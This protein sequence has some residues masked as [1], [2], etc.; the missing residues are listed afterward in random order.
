M[1]NFDQTGP[2]GQGAMTG[3]QMG[4]CSGT[5]GCQDSQAVGDGV[6]LGTG[7]GGVGRGPGLRGR[8]GRPNCCGRGAGLGKGRVFIS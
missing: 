4:K 8:C 7:R 5:K 6:A 1:P 2:R 3:R